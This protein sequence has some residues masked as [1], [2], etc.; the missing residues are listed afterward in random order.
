MVAKRNY[1]DI[2][3]VTAES[4]PVVIRAAFKAL[5]LKY[6]P[7][8]NP[9]SEATARAAEIN[10]AYRTL[11]DAAAREAYDVRM[12]L[13]RGATRSS[14][15]SQPNGPRSAAAPPPPPP[16]NG[17]KA[18]GPKP[19]GPMRLEGDRSTRK[20]QVIG[21][22]LVI[23]LGAIIRIAMQPSSDT[24]RWADT[25]A[26][27]MNDQMMLP[28]PGM[29]ND[30]GEVPQYNTVGEFVDSLPQEAVRPQDVK[31]AANDFARILSK[32]GMLGAENWSQ[33][34][35]AAVERQTTLAGLDNCAAF[36]F[37]A[38]YID[39]GFT[40]GSGLPKNSYFAAQAITQGR[41]YTAT[42]TNAAAVGSRLASIREA[43][44]A[45]TDAAVRRSIANN[46]S[47]GF[48]EPDA[49]TTNQSVTSDYS[50]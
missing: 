9:S 22:F 11:S 32:S 25:A 19:D 49:V 6:H 7:D 8:T 40:S 23:I 48:R 38:A 36:D 34:C 39:E 16:S 5:M 12:G 10:E 21:F 47:T 20:G 4:D 44:M 31:S 33:R 14:E 24:A 26:D 29:V 30:A 3:G 17:G 27:T 41:Y 28:D 45:P 2:L 18:T 43:V 13:R 1:Y 50:R 37:A 46:T 42:V 15:S 35:H